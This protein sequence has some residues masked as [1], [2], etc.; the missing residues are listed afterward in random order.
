MVTETLL[1]IEKESPYGVVANMLDWEIGESEFK[2]QSC[3]DVHFR[4]NTLRIGM[5]PR[6]PS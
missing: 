1:N 6:I 3:Y 2:L 4:T 5:K